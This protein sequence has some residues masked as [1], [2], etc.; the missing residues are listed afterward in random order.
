[1]SD[2]LHPQATSLLDELEATDMPP[3]TSV[4][5]EEARRFLEELFA[6][7]GQDSRSTST[8]C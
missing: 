2:G 1:M 8:R 6:D 5:I 7:R 4:P 3:K